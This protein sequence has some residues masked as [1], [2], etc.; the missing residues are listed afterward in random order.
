VTKFKKKK[1]SLKIVMSDEIKAT[2]TAIR[3]QKSLFCSQSLASRLNVTEKK[4]KTFV[5]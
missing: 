1:I 2:K 5:F 3:G 4:R